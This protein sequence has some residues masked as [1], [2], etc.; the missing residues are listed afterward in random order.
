MPSPALST[1][2]DTRLG[3]VQHLVA[4]RPSGRWNRTDAERAAAINRATVLLICAHLEGFVEGIIVDL[5]DHFNSER[6]PADQLPSLLRASQ[7]DPQLVSVVGLKERVR[8]AQSI[9]KL[10]AQSHSLWLGYPLPKNALRADLVT[11]LMGNPKPTKIA[12]VLHL[13]GMH[14]VFA[15]VELPD[16]A[17][18]EVRLE[19]LVDIRNSIAHGEDVQV[20]DDQVGR[21]VTAVEYFARA[22][23]VGAGEHARQVCRSPER[24]WA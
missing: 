5:F 7:V 1:F 9:D 8:R 14:D 22:L 16:G 18:I 3:E 6:P 17:D 4:L 11:N 23:D 12:E 2:L 19:E 21:Y 10:F 15:A 20:T 13:V 24:P